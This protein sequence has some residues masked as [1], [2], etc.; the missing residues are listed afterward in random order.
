MSTRLTFIKRQIQIVIEDSESGDALAFLQM[1]I[2]GKTGTLYSLIGRHAFLG[3]IRNYDQILDYCDVD[4]VLIVM[5]ASTLKVMMKHVP[6]GFA[7][8]ISELRSAYFAGKNMIECEIIKN[9]QE[10]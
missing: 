10:K 2:N 4:R 7:F 8:S 5:E 1:F 6:D 9:N 3:L